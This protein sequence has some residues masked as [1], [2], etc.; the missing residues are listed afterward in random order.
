MGSMLS[1]IPYKKFCKF[2]LVGGIGAVIQLGMTF[3]LTE[4]I[5]LWYM[6]SLCIAIGL[7]LLWN[8]TLNLVWTFKK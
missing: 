3:I 7:A 6:V 5:G 2:C 8:F 1:R 4:L